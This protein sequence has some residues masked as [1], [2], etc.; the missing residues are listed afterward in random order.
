MFTLTGSGIGNILFNARL[1]NLAQLATQLT[2]CPVQFA[3][4]KAH[5][6]HF[7]LHPVGRPASKR[8]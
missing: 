8:D 1:R 4:K 6:F 5:I 2:F 7:F 3:S